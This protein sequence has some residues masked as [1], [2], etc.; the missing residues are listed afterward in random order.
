MSYIR[1]LLTRS[2][3]AIDSEKLDYSEDVDIPGSPDRVFSLAA[4]KSKLFDETAAVR[5]RN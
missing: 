3:K 5:L 1:K 4:Y 2:G